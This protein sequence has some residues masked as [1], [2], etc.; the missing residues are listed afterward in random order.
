MNINSLFRNL[1]LLCQDINDE[2][3]G[4]DKCLTPGYKV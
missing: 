2:L 1:Y 3:I 4:I